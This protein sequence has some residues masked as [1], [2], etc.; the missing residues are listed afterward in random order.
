MSPRRGRPD[1]SELAYERMRAGSEPAVPLPPQLHRFPRK[2]LLLYAFL[3]LL[4][5]AVLRDG[6]GRPPPEA[7]GSCTRPAFALHTDEV[8][9]DGAVKWSV[10]G[11]DATRVV[12]NADSTDPTRN[13][14][15]GPL[16]LSGCT[17]K[18]VFGARLPDGRHQLRVFLLDADG[19]HTLV[20]EQALTVN[21]P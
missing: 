9:Q 13:V 17:A 15:L 7:G 4:V 12:I 2:K 21:A 3:F 14:L 18:G 6:V 16:A 1:P 11:P 10:D 19:S 20:G 5:V 8:V